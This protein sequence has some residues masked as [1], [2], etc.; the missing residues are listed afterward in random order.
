MD[1]LVKHHGSVDCFQNEVIFCNPGRPKVTFYEELKVLPSCLISAMMARRLSVK[2][3]VKLPKFG[4]SAPLGPRP[5]IS[6]RKVLTSS[7]KFT[8]HV[9]QVWSR[10]SGRIAGDRTIGR[11]SFYV[12]LESFSRSIQDSNS[13]SVSSYTILEVSRSTYFKMRPI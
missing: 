10:S 3:V 8:K 4:Q 13:Q 6:D 7:T 1:W 2:R 5:P 11:S 12:I 9:L